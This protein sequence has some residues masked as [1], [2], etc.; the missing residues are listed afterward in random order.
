MVQ[1]AKRKFP[2]GRYYH[3]PEFRGHWGRCLTDLGRY[4]EA[5]AQLK[6]AYE[7]ELAMRGPD[8]KDTREVVANLVYLYEVW[9]KPDQA[10]AWRAKL[11]AT[12]PAETQP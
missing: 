6:A 12:Q 5:E 10:A 8:H 2:D 4:E 7:G 9:G 1:A 3:L 11:P